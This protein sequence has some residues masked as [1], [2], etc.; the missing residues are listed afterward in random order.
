MQQKEFIKLTAYRLAKLT[1]QPY[2]NW[3]WWDRGR[4]P[5][6]S[7]LKECAKRLNMSVDDLLKGIE[8]RQLEK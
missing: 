6:A 2:H 3:Y 4:R 1:N 8:G 7:T 5:L